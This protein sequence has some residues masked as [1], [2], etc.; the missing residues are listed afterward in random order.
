MRVL[1]A[2][3]AC[4][5]LLLL[6]G[7]NDEV[8]DGMGEREQQDAA[9]R[10]RPTAEQ[11]LARVTEAQEA[12]LTALGGLGL[13]AWE[14][15][16]T[17][18]SSACAEFDESSG[19]VTYLGSQVLPGGVPDDVW[20]RAAQAVEDTAARHG[21]GAADVVVDEPGEHEIVLRGEFGSLLRFGTAK[22]ATLRLATGCHLPE[23]VR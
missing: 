9:L 2:A 15:G 14:P 21:F 18:G 10:E 5:A 6:T 1:L 3:G 8:G 17:T 7:C 13:T 11:A 12:V 22:N 4:A 16:D 20:P 23:S 19:E